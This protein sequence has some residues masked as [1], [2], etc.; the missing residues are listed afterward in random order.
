MTS[1]VRFRDDDAGYLQWLDAHPDGFVLNLRRGESQGYVVLHRAS[2]RFICGDHYERGAF[3]ERG[4]R[5]ACG[6]TVA[7]L[8][9]VAKDE[10]RV[11]GSFSKRCA[12]CNP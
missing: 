7:A 11:D 9:V 8:A 12:F 3:T 1:V 4:Y 10:G 5:K 2:C 6:G